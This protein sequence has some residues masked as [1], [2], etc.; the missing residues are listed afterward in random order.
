VG[1]QDGVF[2]IGVS[3]FRSGS[4]GLVIRDWRIRDWVFGIGSLG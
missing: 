2:R 1:L 3:D 4:S